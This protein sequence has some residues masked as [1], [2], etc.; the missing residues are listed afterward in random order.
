V[1]GLD[2]IE[3]RA[4]CTEPADYANPIEPS[5][6]GG[7]RIAAAVLGAIGL[8]AARPPA[9]RLWAQGE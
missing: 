9:S 8:G 1:R 6:R 7:A 2:I 5:G 4:V 3:L